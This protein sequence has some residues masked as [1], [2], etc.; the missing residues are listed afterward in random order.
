MSKLDKAKG[1]VGRPKKSPSIPYSRYKGIITAGEV[2]NADRN[3]VV[4]WTYTEIANFQKIMK[5]FKSCDVQFIYLYFLKTEIIIKG[6]TNPY[7][8]STK[9]SRLLKLTVDPSDTLGYYVRT[10]Q[11]FKIAIS[12]WD[13][14]LQDMDESCNRFTIVY[15][16]GDS[17]SVEVY[18]VSSVCKISTP[19]TLEILDQDE[20]TKYDEYIS[21]AANTYLTKII[22]IKSVNLK[23]LLGKSTRRNCQK[24]TFISQNKI[25]QIDFELV[26]K[27]HQLINFDV[28]T[29][30]EAKR[31]IK[32]AADSKNGQKDKFYVINST[33]EFCN[34]VFPNIEIYKF[35]LHLKSEIMEIYFTP[36]CVVVRAIKPR[37]IPKEGSNVHSIFTYYVPLD[38]V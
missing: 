16:G 37:V 14:P 23:S 31:L 24:S 34:V 3:P 1:P 15:T 2:V 27:K 18:N 20:L 33:N 35:L 7:N 29:N 13:N 38:N 22:N 6:V 17:F 12:E 30:E 21:I 9:Q 19:V 8:K 32:E 28:Y 5:T 25:C 36:T 4:E 11:R 10:P 26:T